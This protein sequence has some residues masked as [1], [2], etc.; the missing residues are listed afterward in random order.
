MQQQMQMQAQQL[1]MQQMIGGETK[2][3]GEPQGFVNQGT[4]EAIGRPDLAELLGQIN[5]LGGVGGQL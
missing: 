2:G 5:N 4:P 3:G 1:Q